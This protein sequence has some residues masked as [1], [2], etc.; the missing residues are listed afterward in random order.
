LNRQILGRDTLFIVLEK[1]YGIC[2]TG[3][4][5]LS[6]F[7]LKYNML[8]DVLQHP[9]Y[10][11]NEQSF[12]RIYNNNGKIILTGNTDT[13][14]E[15]CGCFYSENINFK[16]NSVTKPKLRVLN[17][18]LKEDRAYVSLQDFDASKSIIK[19]NFILKDDVWHIS[20]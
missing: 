12:D 5:E 9:Y 2:G 10:I 8:K 14:P 17:L 1:R 7:S 6:G 11:N 3:V 16:I 4:S 19:F 13:G 20:K 18:V 15:G